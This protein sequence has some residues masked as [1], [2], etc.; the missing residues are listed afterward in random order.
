MARGVFGG[1][2]RARLNQTTWNFFVG[3]VRR[4]ELHLS[5]GKMPR[6]RSN[7]ACIEISPHRQ[8][9]STS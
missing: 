6:K 1:P 2:D 4:R 3:G 8:R 7:A 5:Q 9:I